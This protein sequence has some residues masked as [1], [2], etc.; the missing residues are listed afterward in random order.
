MHTSTCAMSENIH[1][2][3]Q[4]DDLTSERITE[5]T[6][7]PSLAPSQLTPE[8]RSLALQTL[9]TAADSAWRLAEKERIQAEVELKQAE[10]EMRKAELEKISAQQK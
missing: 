2:S 8:D 7:L 6:V 10:G 9:K 3:L 4:P 1:F 5:L